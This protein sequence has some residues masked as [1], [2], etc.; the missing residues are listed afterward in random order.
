MLNMCNKYM[1]VCF[2][3]VIYTKLNTVVYIS[4]YHSSLP[5]CYI[6]ATLEC[7]IQIHLSYSDLGQRHLSSRSIC[8]TF[9]TCTLQRNTH[10]NNKLHSSIY[11]TRQLIVAIVVCQLLS[12]QMERLDKCL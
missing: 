5:L 4:S 8:V 7:R 10:N 9:R 3:V 6:L 1:I 11:S 12:T 2:Y